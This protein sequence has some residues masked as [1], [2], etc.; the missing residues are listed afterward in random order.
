LACSAQAAQSSA[1]SVERELDRA[2]L[3][4]SQKVLAGWLLAAAPLLWPGGA[5]HA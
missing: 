5:A 2:L 1:S 4:L 3:V